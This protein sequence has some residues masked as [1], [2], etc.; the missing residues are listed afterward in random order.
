MFICI[1]QII[2]KILVS[3]YL[4]NKS[5]APTM[6]YELLQIQPKYGTYTIII[7]ARPQMSNK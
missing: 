6:F 4:L 3:R 7:T 5:I 1:K 2:I